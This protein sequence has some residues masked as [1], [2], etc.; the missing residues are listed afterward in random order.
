MEEHSRL[1]L[2]FKGLFSYMHLLH[3]T[4]E[5]MHKHILC[6]LFKLLAEIICTLERG[7]RYLYLH[8]LNYWINPSSLAKIKD[9]LFLSPQSLDQE[10][11]I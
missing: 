6:K 3:H 10:E 11:I 9:S 7:K 5:I 8:E 1:G 4:V 2:K